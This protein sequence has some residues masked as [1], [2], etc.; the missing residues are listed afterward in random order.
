MAVSDD[1]KVIA[2][3]NTAMALETEDKKL[4]QNKIIPGVKAIFEDKSKGFYL[5]AEL[6]GKIVGQMMVTFEWSDWR[7]ADFWWIQSVYVQPEHR[8][9]NIYKT[10]YNYLLDMA[11][12]QKDVCGIRLYVEKHNTTAQKTYQALGMNPSIYNLYE[13]EI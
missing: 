10:I 12:K 1:Y 4:D 11:G 7:N 9:K 2:E 13:T 6:D 8:R 3:N 5:V